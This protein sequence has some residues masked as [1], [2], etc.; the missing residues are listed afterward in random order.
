LNISTISNLKSEKR[1]KISSVSTLRCS[2]SFD[3]KLAKS[4]MKKTSPKKDNKSNNNDSLNDII[5]KLNVGFKLEDC[6]PED[7]DILETVLEPYL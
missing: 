5:F 1:N 2:Q 6:S 3:D 7:F 4:G